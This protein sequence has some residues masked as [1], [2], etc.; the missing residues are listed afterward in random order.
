MYT[1]SVDHAFDLDAF[2]AEQ[3]RV[4]KPSGYAI[5]DLPR[6]SGSRNPGAFEAIG[7][8][9]EEEIVSRLRQSF[10]TVI[11]TETEKKWQW[12]LLQGP[13]TDRW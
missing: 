11:R 6:Y 13:H 8:K 3:Q 1:N 2:L 9:S 10:K 4:L 12:I 5:Y 7:W